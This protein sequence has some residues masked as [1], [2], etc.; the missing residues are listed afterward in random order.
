MQIEFTKEQYLDLLKLVYCGDTM[1]NWSSKN[2][3]IEIDELTNHIYSFAKDFWCER[4]VKDDKE[5]NIYTASNELEENEEINSYIEAYNTDKDDEVFWEELIQALAERDIEEKN[6]NPMKLETLTELYD[7][8]FVKNG[9][10]NLR[11]VK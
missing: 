9:V 11:V 6:K 10:K 2:R 7:Q 5:D 3:N 4:Y 8:E 1:I